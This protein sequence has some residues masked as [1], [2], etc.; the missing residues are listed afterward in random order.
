MSLIIQVKEMRAA[1]GVS[2]FIMKASASP[3]LSII[4][5]AC[6]SPFIIKAGASPIRISLIKRVSSRLGLISD[7]IKRDAPA[8]GR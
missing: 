1:R 4:M 3:I 5:K 8:C 7:L 2:P 6:A